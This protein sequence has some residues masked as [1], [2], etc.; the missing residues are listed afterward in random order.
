[1]SAFHAGK[2]SPAAFPGVAPNLKA[3]KPATN[4]TKPNSTS[5]PQRPQRPGRRK[6]MAATDASRA[7]PPQDELGEEAGPRRIHARNLSVF[8]PHPEQLIQQPAPAE[9]AEEADAQVLDI[10]P[11]TL[12]AHSPSFGSAG[13]PRTR[14]GHHHRHSLSHNFFPFLAEKPV[15][16][17]SSGPTRQSLE[18]EP[19][20]GYKKAFRGPGIEEQPLISPSWS[21]PRTPL[22]PNSALPKPVPTD[23]HHPGIV[24]TLPAS[25]PRARHTH[26]PML[27]R[28]LYTVL[29]MPSRL[30][31]LRILVAA[32]AL[33]TGAT[34]WL[35]GQQTDCLSLAGL[36]YLLVFDA[37]GAA[38]ALL[39]DPRPDDGTDRLWDALGRKDAGA[40]IRLP[41]GRARLATL[42]IFTQALFLLFSAIY[43]CKEAVEHMMMSHPHGPDNAGGGGGSHVGHSER[44]Q[45]EMEISCTL[46]GSAIGLVLFD[47]LVSRNHQAMALIAA[48]GGESTTSGGSE[49]ML[50]AFS[51]LSLGFGLLVMVCGCFISPSQSGKADGLIAL[52]LVFAI[53]KLVW[54]VLVDTG[55]VL[56][57]TAP[58]EAAGS[59]AEASTLVRRLSALQKDPQ[60][61]PVLKT[62]L[63]GIE[64]PKLWRLTA[65][66]QGLLVCALDVRVRDDTPPAALLRVSE[67][68]RT[69]LHSLPLE[70][71]VVIKCVVQ[72]QKKEKNG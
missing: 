51:T 26:R 7:S 38:H 33:A 63:A 3:Q 2:C 18:D 12:L 57:Q 47:A 40:S 39:F 43:V 56:L 10:P 35:R 22:T 16:A 5:H 28:L 69:A 53:V 1:M 20:P 14:R 48:G 15:S 70:L 29:A 59:S 19:R 32:L 52:L 27:L 46:V 36:G 60:R 4:Q 17:G 8:F 66:P 6:P 9:S 55:S 24:R 67:A 68:V 61:A 41:F 11:A 71:T 25:S 44:H 72:P 64:R 50:N 54:P 42:S 37:L 65:S 21:F 49:R 23:L 30:V 13:S 31:Q 34:L 45:S 58:S 62:Y